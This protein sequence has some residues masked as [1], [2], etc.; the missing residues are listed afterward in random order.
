MRILIAEDDKGL[1]EVIQKKMKAQ[2]FSVDI[3]SNG[4]D[5]C[6]YLI[7][8][9]YDVAV[10]DIMMPKMDG[11]QVVR[12]IR[13]KGISTPVIFLTAKDT[14]ADK[15]KGLDVGANDYVVKP[16]A[17]EELFARIRAVTRTAAVST[18]NIYSLADLTL[19][20]ESHIVMRNGKEIE[21][22]GR[23]YSLLEYLMVNKGKI[24]SRAKIEDHVWGLDYPGGG[25]VVDVYINYLRKKVD[26]GYDKKLIFTVRGIGFVLKEEEP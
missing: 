25:T 19:D 4:E 21:L 8:G 6:D 18:S 11:I 2:G 26:Q 3:F 16:F 23:E 22:T 1:R 5:A 24:L 7:D 15:V 14:I 17:F 13:D 9:D 10:L 20:V 12:E